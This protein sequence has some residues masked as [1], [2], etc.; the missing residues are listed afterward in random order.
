MLVL[1]FWADC[2]AGS[3]SIGNIL[4]CWALQTAIFEKK[5]LIFIVLFHWNCFLS[6]ILPCS[7]SPPIKQFTEVPSCFAFLSFSECHS[8]MACQGRSKTKKWFEKHE[9]RGIN[10][11]WIILFL[12]FLFFV[13]QAKVTLKN[14][15]IKRRVDEA[16]M[17]GKKCML[18]TSLISIL[19]K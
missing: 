13:L 19:N 3:Y 16:F 5:K 15:S 1:E 10:K 6:P 2:D 12:F 8:L 4:L 18:L 14:P 9:R 7:T 11:H 17:S